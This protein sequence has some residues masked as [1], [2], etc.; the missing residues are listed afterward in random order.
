MKLKSRGRWF[1]WNIYMAWW[2]NE[3]ETFSALLAICAGNS[4]VPVNSPHKGQWRRALMFSLICIWINSWVN[5]REAGDSG[6]HRAHYDVIVMSL[7][8]RGS[9]SWYAKLF[10]RIVY[11][12]IYISLHWNM[13]FSFLILTSR[14]CVD[15]H[16]EIL[17]LQV[18]QECFAINTCRVDSNKFKWMINSLRLS[19]AYIYQYTRPSLVEIVVCCLLDTKPLSEPMLPYYTPR[20]NE[21]DR[22]VYWYH[23]VRL[24]T[25]SC[26]LCIFNNTHPIHFIFAHL[27]KQLQKVC[28]V[29]ISKFKNLK[30]W[31]IF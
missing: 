23:L 18:C 4:T 9:S 31:R 8:G 11:L 7:V 10:W 15:Q 30:F 27:I 24:W 20:F 21:V 17:F 12:E 6:R 1:S 28:R 3:M 26:P 22:G 2:H 29:S 13:H 25:E 16:K 19:D 5:N 14:W